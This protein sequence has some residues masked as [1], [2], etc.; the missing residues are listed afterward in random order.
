VK[1]LNPKWWKSVKVRERLWMPVK[2]R[3]SLWM[4]LKVRESLWMS[5]KVRESLWN[6]VKVCAYLLWERFN[7]NQKPTDLSHSYQTGIAN[8]WEIWRSN[9]KRISIVLHSLA[10]LYKWAKMPKHLL[11]PC[12]WVTWNS[13]RAKCARNSFRLSTDGRR[14]DI[15]SSQRCWRLCAALFG[16]GCG[17]IGLPG[18]EINTHRCFETSVVY[19]SQYGITYQTRWICETVQSCIS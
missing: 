8:S 14:S 1:Y 5:V 4:S 7:N 10:L 9:M 6:S 12:G 11:S 18:T 19:S 13:R 17:S 3:E 16:S 15:C 2:V